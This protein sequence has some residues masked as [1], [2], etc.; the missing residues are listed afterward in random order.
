MELC[1]KV[2]PCCGSLVMKDPPGA[3]TFVPGILGMNVICRCYQELFVV[4]GSSL[5]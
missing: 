4:L 5:F 1:G 2:V 3:S